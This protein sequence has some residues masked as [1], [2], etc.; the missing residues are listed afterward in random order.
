MKHF[1]LGLT[2]TLGLVSCQS[3]Q[4]TKTQTTTDI[5]GREATLSY[6]EMTAEVKYISETELHWETTDAQGN[7]AE[8]TEALS[9]K[10]IAEHKFFLNWVE[11]DGTTVSQVLDFEQGT[12]LAYL[13]Y[14][15]STG[16]GGRAATLLEGTAKI[17]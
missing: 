11:A 2:L 1:L 16:R 5:I 12:V 15:D 3:S 6:P 8:G 14:A 9:Y 4:E 10:R 13:S 17:K 7:K